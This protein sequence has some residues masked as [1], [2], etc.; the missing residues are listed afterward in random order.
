MVSKCMN[1]VYSTKTTKTANRVNSREWGHQ[2][3]ID[4]HATVA[5]GN[6]RIFARGER[7]G[8]DPWFDFMKH[9]RYAS[10]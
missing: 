10:L 3:K 9:V 1:Q 5:V 7:Y 4:D 2:D 6:D 8:V